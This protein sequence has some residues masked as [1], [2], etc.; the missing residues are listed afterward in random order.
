[1]AYT[2]NQA[3][4]RLPWQKVVFAEEPRRSVLSMLPDGLADRPLRLVIHRNAPVEYL[5]GPLGKYLAFDG[6]SLAAAPG[7][8]DDS[9]LFQDAGTGDLELVWLDFSRYLERMPPPSLVQWL[10]ERLAELR[11]RS[12]APILVAGAEPPLDEGFDGLLQEALTGLG[13]VRV[14]PRLPLVRH[15]GGRYYDSRLAALGA[16]DKSDAAFLG[17]ARE[18]GLVWIP[19]ALGPGLKALALDLDHTLYQGVLG[20]DGIPGVQLT[21]AHAE[22]QRRILALREDGFLLALVSRN[23]AED[24]EALFRARQ[25]F[26]L[27][28]EHF[29]AFQVNWESKALGVARA[30]G[31]L[32]IGLDAILF[33]DDNP[34]ELA[35][36]AGAH[37]QVR[38][39]HAADPGQ[40]LRG[41]RWFPGLARW[42]RTGAD[43]LRSRD[44][45]ANRVRASLEQTA[46]NPA[47]YLR[48]LDVRIQLTRRAV[49]DLPRLLEL[50]GKT[51]QFNVAL[52]R[53]NEIEVRKRVPD[54]DFQ[55]VSGALSDRLSDSGVVMALFAS[56]TPDGLRVEDL[57]ISCRA[58]G[59][60]LEDILVTAAL[61]GLLE[62]AGTQVQ[63]PYALG[64]R[65]GPGRAWLAQYS[66]VALAEQ[67][68][69]TLD[70]P[71]AIRRRS[72]EDVPVA[73][74][75]RRA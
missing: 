27:R 75:W 68:M 69:V 16:T 26:P 47:E 44:L 12:D 2:I 21:P 24:V 9:L 56:R 61:D 37:P 52:R 70:W 35:A 23:E 10:G 13:A 57:C 64:P 4:E 28:R 36:V 14:V 39:L 22:L 38:L 55:W 53:L 66:G 41:L 60:G 18:L 17:M 1:M 67:G 50:S 40:S 32:R 33:M 58:L 31:E 3:M 48:S 54:P 7:P 71:C 30:A 19:A 72:I 11:R 59:R 73:M 15:L 74:S 29:S 20:E 51:N 42:T 34:G 63:F 5:L 65:N 43:A 25:D 46:S 8:Y 62:G 49:E 6:W 45:E